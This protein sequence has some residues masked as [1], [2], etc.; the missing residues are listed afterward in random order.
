MKVRRLTK[1][2][3]KD[4]NLTEYTFRFIPNRLY[5]FKVLLECLVLAY[6]VNQCSL[7]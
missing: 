1:K 5:V 2:S 3:P 7:L 6:E 4:N